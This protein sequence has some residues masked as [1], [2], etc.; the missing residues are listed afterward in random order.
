MVWS[1]PRGN[2]GCFLTCWP[3][4]W[5]SA[6]PEKR[7]SSSGTAH[8]SKESAYRQTISNGPG[9]T[10]KELLP[11]GRFIHDYMCLTPQWTGSAS[12]IH[13]QVNLSGAGRFIQQGCAELNSSLCTPSAWGGVSTP[14]S[15]LGQQEAL[16]ESIPAYTYPQADFWVLCECQNI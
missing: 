15:A 9:T 1:M 8:T 7:G 3:F 11:R 6:P 13:Q 14:V 16:R 12:V 5:T 10:L 4:L 2:A